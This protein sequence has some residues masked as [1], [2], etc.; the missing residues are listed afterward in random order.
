[1]ETLLSQSDINYT[2]LKK[3]LHR[4]TAYELSSLSEPCYYPSLKKYYYELL[5]ICK[6]KEKDV[7]QY[8]TRFYKGTPASK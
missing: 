1:M 7:T 3:T 5:H 4:I 2:K 8:V 6:L